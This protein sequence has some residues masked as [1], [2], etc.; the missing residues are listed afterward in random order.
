MR[1]RSGFLAVALALVLSAAVAPAG[2]QQRFGHVFLIVGEN[3]SF[4]LIT[5]AHAPFLTRTIKPRGVWLTNYHSFT[6]SSSLGEYIAMVSGQYTKCEGS[7]DLP[8]H[9]HQRVPNLFT[10]L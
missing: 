9:C 6:A 10:Q 1:R 3:T 2:A 4:E 8:D 7:N 5:P